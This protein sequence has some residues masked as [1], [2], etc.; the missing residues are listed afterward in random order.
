M[1]E[2]EVA[3][4]LH[5]FFEVLARFKLWHLLRRNRQ[6]GA[7]FWV[8]A[9]S[10]FPSGSAKCSEAHEFHVISTRNSTGNDFERGVEDLFAL[11]L[12]QQSLAG[13]FV[14]QL[15][16]VHGVGSIIPRH[17]RLYPR[18]VGGTL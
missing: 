8:P 12:G 15:S 5:Q 10:R 7:C 14:D 1:V 9:G 17:T 6:R 13:H 16:F 18:S 3:L 4:S 11:L 2:G